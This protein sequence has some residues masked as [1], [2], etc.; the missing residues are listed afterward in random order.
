[1]E[2]DNSEAGQ[3]AMYE[4]TGLGHQGTTFQ[5]EFVEVVK[6][7]SQKRIVERI[8]GVMVPQFLKEIVEVAD[9]VPKTESS[10]EL[11]TRSWKVPSGRKR[12]NSWRFLSVFR[13]RGQRVFDEAD[14][15]PVCR[16]TR[17]E[18]YSGAKKFRRKERSPTAVFAEQIIGTTCFF[19]DGER[20]G[21]P[22]CLHSARTVIIKVTMFTLQVVNTRLQPL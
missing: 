22:V 15:G 4:S 20:K 5:E 19:S 14:T 9:V 8:V 17:G 21:H 12:R 2:I 7:T 13:G 6:L 11:P 18:C 10:S 3:T 16:F 1:M